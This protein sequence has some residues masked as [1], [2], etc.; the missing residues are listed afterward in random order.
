M[1][2]MQNKAEEHWRDKKN[3]KGGEGRVTFPFSTS[4]I[5]RDWHLN[6][7]ANRD[8]APK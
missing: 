4:L 8:R 6:D 1:A 3:T 7:H 5:S 2:T